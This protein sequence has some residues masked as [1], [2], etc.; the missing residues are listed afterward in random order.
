MKPPLVT[1]EECE[2]DTECVCSEQP[3]GCPLYRATRTLLAFADLLERAET[4]I[5]NV[6]GTANR[7]EDALLDDIRAA[8]DAFGRKEK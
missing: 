3:E 1:R 7:N 6:Y 5:A 4:M 2:H 8:L